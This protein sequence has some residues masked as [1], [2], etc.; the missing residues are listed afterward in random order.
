MTCNPGES[1]LP[2]LF[3]FQ[4][5][6]HNVAVFRGADLKN[7]IASGLVKGFGGSA[8]LSARAGKGLGLGAVV[9][10]SAAVAVRPAPVIVKAAPVAIRRPTPVIVKPRPIAVRPAPLAVRPAPVIIKPRPVAIRPAPVYRTTPA[11]V[12]PAYID[13]SYRIPLCF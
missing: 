9:R 5:P 3:Q 12:E 6:T 8:G 7:A 10:P 1:S 4:Q 2:V 11:Y 13:V